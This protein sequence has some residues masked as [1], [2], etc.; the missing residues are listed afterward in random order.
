MR[1]TWMGL[2]VA[3]T[4][5]AFFVASAQGRP[6]SD[7]DGKTQFE[8]EFVGV[9]NGQVKLQL[10]SGKYLSV[11]LDKLS[12]EDRQF[13]KQAKPKSILG[14][15]NPA[16]APAGAAVNE[17]ARQPANRF[18]AAVRDNPSDSGAH[19]ARGLNNIHDGKFD[20]AIGDFD[21]AIELDPDN[22]P[23]YDG[24]GMAYSKQGD[25]IRARADFDQAIKLDPK[26]ATAYRHRAENVAEWAKT[27]EGKAA[28]KELK[29]EARE[30]RDFA[31]KRNQKEHGWQPLHST[32][33]PM[34][35]RD[36]QDLAKQDR[37]MAE[38]LEKGEG[39][40]GAGGGGGSGS[41]SGK[42]G[43]PG[44]GGSGSGAGGSGSG[45]GGQGQPKPDA[46]QAL[47]VSPDVAPKGDTVTLTADAEQLAKNMPIA[48]PAAGKSQSGKSQSGKSP[49]R[50]PIDDVSFYRD[51]N[52]NGKLDKADDLL[53]VDQD[54]SDGFSA[55][56]PTSE[57]PTGDQ[58]YF[59]VPEGAKDA[60]GKPS[61]G[62][63]VT[64]TGKITPA[65]PNPVAAADGGNDSKSGGGS[66][67]G[68]NGNG[69]GGAGGNGGNRDH[70]RDF[71]VQTAIQRALGLIDA[72]DYERAIRE[73]DRLIVDQPDNVEYRR[74][75]ARTYFTDGRYDRAAVDY[76][77]LIERDTKNAD[78]YYNRGCAYLAAG[79]LDLAIADFTTSIELNETGHLA[80]TN[81]G[82]AYARQGDYAKAAADFTEA[83]R[84][85]PDDRVAYRNRALAYKHLGMTDQAEADL[86][87]LKKLGG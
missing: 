65:K 20:E 86:A 55:Q 78:L 7:A 19:Y 10:K 4:I 42:G 23:A 80:Y 60:N 77:T 13:V 84:H 44:S 67:S 1:R 21:K 12:D 45:G 35:L 71:D 69:G 73:Y 85:A 14:P 52:G 6:W 29:E 34:T 24:R 53:A 79:E 49:Q 11:P 43:G 8:A 33:G 83:L 17:P 38:R 66:A 25:P 15:Q 58:T 18:D 36:L 39:S 41:G 46:T 75:R 70:V 22:A 5:A 40:S 72:G 62:K 54:G 32:A 59:A 74:A 81:R 26:L 57:F 28:Q 87:A 61:K 48:K 9:A 16:K 47:V 68:G 2:S 56:V 64:G 27:D 82:S 63:F 31:A 3:V 37:E 51:T 30:E 50:E 76:G